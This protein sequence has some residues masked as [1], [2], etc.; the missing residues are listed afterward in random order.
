MRVLVSWHYIYHKQHYDTEKLK[1][2]NFCGEAFVT[3]FKALENYESLQQTAFECLKILINECKEKSE[4]GW[5]VQ[6]SFLD[7]LSDY[8]NWTAASIKRLSYY[9]L[10]FPKNF[11][12][13][14]CEQ[15][16]EILKKLLQTS[17]S[18]NKDQNYL[19]IAKNNEHELKIAAIIDLFHLI[20]ACTPKFVILLIRLILAVE[21]ED[22]VGLETSCPYRKPLIKFLLRYPEET[23]TFLLSD[24]N[25]KNLQ[26][27]RFTIYLLKHK[28]GSAFKTV[29]ENRGHR[30]KELILKDKNDARALP[31]LFMTSVKSENESQHQAVLII[32]TIIEQND[33]WLASQMSIV[34]ALNQVWKN[35]LLGNVEQ[36]V[37]NNF[38]HLT[39]KILLHYFEHN[40]GDIELLFQLLKVFNKRCI[41]D[42]QVY[43]N[44]FCVLNKK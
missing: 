37:T 34:T 6:E 30:L 1:N 16:F 22:G 17:I 5:P 26:Y 8:M 18:A 10:L 28:D 7:T 36:N 14:V 33:Q 23:V 24:D 43:R 40:P 11:P 13:K 38:W 21:D 39:T 31:Q 25:V 3:L 9:C 41:P 20:P 32:Y 12:E 42:F 2:I 4:T 35:D 15:L 27:N 19:K 44:N 29:M